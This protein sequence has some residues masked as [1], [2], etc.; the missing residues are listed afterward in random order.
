[1]SSKT[2]NCVNNIVKQRFEM[3]GSKSISNCE[4]GLKFGME[5]IHGMDFDLESNLEWNEFNLEW[6]SNDDNLWKLHVWIS[7]FECCGSSLKK[8]I[9]SWNCW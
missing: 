4:V 3:R 9:E 5:L 6:I 7:M 8:N 2:L 1:M